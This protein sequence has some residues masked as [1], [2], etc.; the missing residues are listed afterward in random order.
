[1]G[2]DKERRADGAMITVLV[3]LYIPAA[4]NITKEMGTE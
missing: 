1:M 2:K 3:N 4:L